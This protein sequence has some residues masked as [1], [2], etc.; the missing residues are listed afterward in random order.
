MILDQ[1]NPHLETVQPRVRLSKPWT[2]EIL[3]IEETGILVV[4]LYNERTGEIRQK[5]VGV[6][7]LARLVFSSMIAKDQQ[8]YKQPDAVLTER[9]V[10]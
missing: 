3:L 10:K 1:N 2:P 6:D 9:R 8:N 5:R 4:S 7:T